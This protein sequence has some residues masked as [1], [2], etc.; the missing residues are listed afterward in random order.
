ML[1]GIYQNGKYKEQAIE[2]LSWFLTSVDAAKAEGIIRGMYGTAKIREAMKATL[3]G[4]EL[5]MAKLLNV[6][7]AENNPP[8]QIDPVNRLKWEDVLTPEREKLIFGQVTLDDF[9]K[10]V[11]KYADPVLIE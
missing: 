10:N 9:F 11:Q 5:A 7:D 2:F 3:S 1:F 4:P 8:R 6:V